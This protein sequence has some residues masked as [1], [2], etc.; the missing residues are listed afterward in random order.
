[1]NKDMKVSEILDQLCFTETFKQKITSSKDVSP[2]TPP[3]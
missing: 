3:A 2:N 1:M